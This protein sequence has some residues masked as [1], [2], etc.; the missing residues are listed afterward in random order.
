MRSVE[1]ESAVENEREVAAVAVVIVVVVVVA[2]LELP[3]PFLDLVLLDVS[4]LYLYYPLQ[5]CRLF[6][7]TQF[8]SHSLTLSL[9]LP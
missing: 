6:F 8:I 9:S 3:F 5:C 2:G 1:Y 7:T 4:S